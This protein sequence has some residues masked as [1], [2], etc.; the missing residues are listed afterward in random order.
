MA[1]S[2]E[3]DV[4]DLSEE[5]IEAWRR[6]VRDSTF[7]QYHLAM[8]LAILHTEGPEQALPWIEE[9]ARSVSDRAAGARIKIDILRALG[10]EEEARATGVAAERVDPNFSAVGLGR[11]ARICLDSAGIP[12]AA[13]DETCRRAIAAFEAAGA[14]GEAD[15]TRLEFAAH[16][17]AIGRE[18]EASELWRRVSEA[19]DAPTGIDHDLAL[20]HLELIETAAQKGRRDLALAGCARILSA[21]VG[22]DDPHLERRAA[23]VALDGADA[24]PPELRDRLIGLLV[25]VADA[26]V[27]SAL[28]RRARA[29]GREDEAIAAWNRAIRHDPRHVEADHELAIV[30]HDAGDFALALER[31]RDG[32]SGDPDNVSLLI[33]KALSA[34]GACDFAAGL[35]ACRRLR[36]VAPGEAF[37]WDTEPLHLIGIG[38]F[39][40][41]AEA[42]AAAVARFGDDPVRS[43]R[44]ALALIADGRLDEARRAAE[45]A[46]ALSGGV[47]RPPF[48]V[49]TT[50]IAQGRL[51]EAEAALRTA[52]ST[53][54]PG[55]VGMVWARLAALADARGRSD[56]VDEALREAAARSAWLPNH[57][58][59]YPPAAARLQDRARGLGII[60]GDRAG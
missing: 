60:A 7:A 2:G 22:R 35:D 46:L 28:A 17:L 57:I 3:R 4:S 14:R 34:L 45:T 42:S 11:A 52:L 24:A 8:G 31:C 41:A 36:E 1:R 54:P 49:A 15:R 30:A 29:A 50:A 53:A 9:A 47:E 44:H 10:R 12:D 23:V 48:A 38:D 27:Q 19:P 56:E 33:R 39:A 6:A 25:E 55:A 20:A 5:G 43:A 59:M 18:D 37:S 32:L 51:D 26:D 16:L 21:S 40:A 58:R 13:K